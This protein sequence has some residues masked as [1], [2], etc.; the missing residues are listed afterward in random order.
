MRRLINLGL[1][2]VR[3]FYLTSLD[4]GWIINCIFCCEQG[5]DKITEDPVKPDAV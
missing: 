3:S 1:D 2:V 5:R 4:I